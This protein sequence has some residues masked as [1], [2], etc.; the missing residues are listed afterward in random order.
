MP[1]L[2][3]LWPNGT[4]APFDALMDWTPIGGAGG[5]F[6]FPWHEGLIDGGETP[7]SLSLRFG[8]TTIYP[9]AIV[10]ADPAATAQ[11]NSASGPITV[12][13]APVVSDA[14]VLATNAVS[15]SE[16]PLATPSV[17][18]PTLYVHQNDTGG[19]ATAAITVSNIA[20]PDE[21][22]E[23]LLADVVNFDGSVTAAS[24][25]TGDIAPGASDSTSLTATLPTSNLGPWSGDVDVAVFSDGTG[26]DS[27]G[28]TAL[29]T[30]S[31]AVTI[32]VDQ[33]AVAAIQQTA[34]NGTLLPTG[35]ASIYSLD[36]GA[37]LLNGTPLTAGLEV[38]N[39][40][41][42]TADQLNGGFSIAGAPEFDNS[43]FDPFQDVASQ[44]ADSAPAVVL[45]SGT[46]GAFIETIILN[47]TGSNPSGY[48]AALGPETVTITG[49]VL[50][51]STPTPAPAPPEPEATAWGDVHLTTFD[52]VYYNFQA[53]GEYV[54]TRSTVAGDTF[55]VQARLAAVRRQFLGRPCRPRSAPRS[56]AT[57]WSSR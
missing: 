55:Q 46:V 19:S 48:S 29:G 24:G 45:S 14:A 34:G 31:V 16:F 53:A 15:S 7:L 3:W 43:G 32:D 12:S 33:Y 1:R 13:D 18:A 8:G 28:T 6:D 44:Q 40:V 47:P 42:G 38:L 26:I 11:G 5:R 51:A 54:L 41:L 39:D 30:I 22:Y 10:G 49:T 35:V 36:L 37:T 27:S 9:G 20:P 23:N 50:P 21:G 2:T 17:T 56:A 52:G 4:F 57:T 25:A